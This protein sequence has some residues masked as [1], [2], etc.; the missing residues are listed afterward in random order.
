MS[1]YGFGLRMVEKK[2]QLAAKETGFKMPGDR[3][4]PAKAEE[5]VEEKSNED[6][7]TTGPS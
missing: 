1:L 4:E 2:P 3:A 6:T 7:A 5:R